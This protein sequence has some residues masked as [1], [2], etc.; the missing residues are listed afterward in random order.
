[1]FSAG[2]KS[3][4]DYLA[5]MFGFRGSREWICPIVR[6]DPRAV[7][8]VIDRYDAKS[9]VLLRS[10]AVVAIVGMS[11][12]IR[13]LADRC[14]LAEDCP[15]DEICSNAGDRSHQGLCLPNAETTETGTTETETETTETGTTET[16]TTETGTES[17]SG[18]DSDSTDSSTT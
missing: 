2:L 17:E 5:G 11:A 18:N 4:R 7:E 6:G 12:C 8:I 15:D 10:I 1:M 3:S 16:G 14:Y 13:P 9:M